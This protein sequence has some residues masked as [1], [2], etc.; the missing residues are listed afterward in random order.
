MS[1]LKLY[2]IAN[3]RAF[4][5]VWAAEELG[6]DYEHVPVTF[7]GDSKEQSYLDVNPNGRIPALVDGDLRLFESMAINM[8]LAK[9]YGPHLL[10][11]DAQGEAQVWQWSV[12]GISEIEPMQMA[13]VVQQFFTPEEK[14]DQKIFDRSARGLLRPLQV[15]DTHLKSHLWLLGDDFTLADLNLAAVMDLLNMLQHDVSEFTEVRRWLD[16]CYARPSYAA[17][18]AVG[19]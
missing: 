5:S 1:K 15:L 12:W 10:P 11:A 4:R 3:S 13:M 19:A 8:Y 6:L 2:G 7:G 18:K 14:R 16:T 17:A 9:Q